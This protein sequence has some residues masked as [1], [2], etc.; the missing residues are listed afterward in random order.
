MKMEMNKTFRVINLAIFINL[1][2]L[3]LS[4]LTFAVL[5][6]S[7]CSKGG[8]DE[9]L[10]DDEG[11]YGKVTFNTQ[12]LTLKSYITDLIPVKANILISG[13][14]YPVYLKNQG[15]TMYALD[16]TLPDG[17]YTL[18]SGVFENHN[19]K[20]V[21]MVKDPVNFS[22]LT[23][24][25]IT[26]TLELVNYEE[27]VSSVVDATFP[28]VLNLGD[29]NLQPADFNDFLVW[30]PDTIIC[31]SASFD[32]NN[33][34]NLLNWH[35]VFDFSS[36]QYIINGIALKMNDFN[37][38]PSFSVIGNPILILST[39]SAFNLAN[40]TSIDLSQFKDEG[41]TLNLGR[42]LTDIELIR[43]WITS[44]ISK[45]EKITLGGG[46]IGI[47][48]GLKQYYN[49]CSPTNVYCNGTIQDLLNE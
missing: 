34:L 26:V 40:I 41:V 14:N 5:M 39:D 12:I 20:P 27:G 46:D 23:G 4:L 15:G 24:Q 6:L 13:S 21:L 30:R 1:S 19:S 9:V 7:S 36:F 11:G 48:N 43:T 45:I 38:L 18:Q 37:A 47:N 2:I 44:N 28:S 33:D 29:G 16:L 22:V 35:T 17:S 8:K 32:L 42:N 49:D 10:P 25:T 31:Q 3:I